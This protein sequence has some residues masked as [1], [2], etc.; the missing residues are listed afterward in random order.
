MRGYKAEVVTVEAGSRGV[1]D[2]RSLKEL[3]RILTPI[4]TK[5]WRKFMLQLSTTVLKESHRIWCAR[6]S[7]F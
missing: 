2:E 7:R 1:L 3:R 6:N 5:A 4:P